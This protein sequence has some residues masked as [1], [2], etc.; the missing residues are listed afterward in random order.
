MYFITTI[1]SRTDESR[2]V[3][4]FSSFEEAE[5]AVE[6]NYLDLHETIYDYIV[7]ENIPEGLYRYDQD[8]KWYKWN[9]SK[10]RYEKIE[11]RPE[12]YSNIV[13]FGI[14]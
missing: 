1:Q 12:E 4:Y 6:E 13:G 3:G 11:G 14:G 9:N 10:E 5:E 8:A 7:I 2:C